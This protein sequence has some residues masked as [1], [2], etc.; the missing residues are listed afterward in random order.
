MSEYASKHLGLRRP[1]WILSLIQL[2]GGL[3]LLL[4]VAIGLI[5]ILS[6]LIDYYGF[7][8]NL[9]QLGETE[10]GAAA[11]LQ[12]RI[13]SATFIIYLYIF[14]PALMRFVKRGSK[15]VIGSFSEIVKPWMPANIPES[16]RDYGEVERGFKERTLGIYE[17]F[18]AFITG[19]M[20]GNSMFVTPSR[21]SIVEENGVELK[22]RVKKLIFAVL[23]LII[24]LFSPRW[25]DSIV[26]R[27]VI[28][29]ADLGIIYPWIENLKPIALF[30]PFIT[31]VVLQAL[32]S[33]TEFISMLAL[34]PRSH[35]STV[36][37]E[38]IEHYRGFGHPDQIFSRLPDL[39]Q[40]LRWQGFLN[41]VDSNWGERAS[42]AIGDVGEFHG[43]II[44]EQQPRPLQNTGDRPA[45]LMLCFGWA[46][47]F[48][49]MITFLFLL[50]PA[51]IMNPGYHFLYAP[52]YVAAMG[53]AASG[54]ERS[55]YRF[56]GYA[57]TILQSAQFRSL[58]ILI[59]IDGTL[60]RAD[61]RVGKSIADSVE[62]S[63]VVVRS[64]FSA[65]LWASELL[66]EAA[67]LDA[68]RE[69][70][71][72]DQS[73]ESESWISFFREG[74]EQLR[75]EGIRP[76]G[77][78]LA[79]KEVDQILKANIG[80]S[81]LRS[82]AIEKAQLSAGSAGEDTPLLTAINEEHPSDQDVIQARSSAFAADE[83]KECPE[84]AEMIRA[85]AIK[86]RF[87]GYRFDQS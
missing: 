66:S 22:D 57:R 46:L 29:I 45:Y 86:C 67:R 9:H 64:D 3:L 62:S 34:V 73:D 65:R 82:S 37:Q 26:A 32:F 84:C 38:G 11:R 24:V 55:G 59:Q 78:D 54:A 21:R 35:P 48:I 33:L 52:F 74:I 60:S 81:A 1:P 12:S 68:K 76:I 31:L 47:S 18:D 87:C 75:D 83:Y 19:I 27:E 36:A 56:I 53:L 50:L 40:S 8:L 70:L 25:L 13:F 39:A 61:I 7:G 72:L 10:R 58:A 17:P 71:A 14:I 80:L 43:R 20:G 2:F 5:Y 15:L 77:V 6:R 28:S 69:L 42:A 51:N 41:R 85:K 63:N 4:I 49:G 30:L 23:G 16:F 79:T 44:I